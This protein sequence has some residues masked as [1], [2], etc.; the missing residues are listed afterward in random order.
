MIKEASSRAR[1]VVT[2][3]WYGRALRAPSWC[4]FTVDMYTALCLIQ[5]LHAA[6]GVWEM[7]AVAAETEETATAAWVV[8][9]A[10]IS[11]SCISSNTAA[12]R[13][14]VDS[15]SSNTSGAGNNA[16]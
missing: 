12:G 2:T 4:T 6:A 13:G 8:A 14:G 5:Y 10:S 1:G 16:V 3:V 11:S 7:A 15:S 9:A